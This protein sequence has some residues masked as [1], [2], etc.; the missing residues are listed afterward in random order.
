MSLTVN[1]NNLARTTAG[2]LCFPLSETNRM[3][4]QIQASIDKI[5]KGTNPV[6][7]RNQ[8]LTLNNTITGLVASLHTFESLDSTV[9]SAPPTIQTGASLPSSGIIAPP[10]SAASS[11]NLPN[12]PLPTQAANGWYRPSDNETLYPY[13]QLPRLSHGPMRRSYGPISPRSYRRAYQD[14]HY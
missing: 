8:L 12:L 5:L 3:L 10:T 2:S 1:Q 7:N 14:Y 4:T 6:D 13:D 9:K 11:Q